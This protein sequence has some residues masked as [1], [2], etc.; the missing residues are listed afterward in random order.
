MVTGS[1]RHKWRAWLAVAAA[2]AFLTGIVLSWQLF[3][4]GQYQAA[5][6]TFFLFLLLASILS[7]GWFLELANRGNPPLSATSILP[8]ADWYPR[9]C[10]ASLQRLDRTRKRTRWVIGLILAMMLLHEHLPFF[11]GSFERL[12]YVVDGRISAPVLALTIAGTAPM[13]LFFVWVTIRYDHLFR[14]HYRW[15]ARRHDAF[16][17]PEVVEAAQELYDRLRLERPLP[18]RHRSLE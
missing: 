10:T 17:D 2:A 8:V 5:G 15:M 18:L 14:L 11:S 12:P 1:L 4:N 16:R 9:L 3:G 7:V 6:T 13:A